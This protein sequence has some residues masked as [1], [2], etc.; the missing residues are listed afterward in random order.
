MDDLVWSHLKK[1]IARRA[2]ELALGREFEAV[3]REAKERAARA[4][5]PDDLWDLER[6]LTQT[7]KEIDSKYD[8]RYS[9][10][11]FVFSRLIVEGRLSEQELGGLRQDKLDAIRHILAFAAR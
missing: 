2:F 1:T 3:M 7:R 10:L 11:I 5:E 6:F 9:V 4:K 8:Y